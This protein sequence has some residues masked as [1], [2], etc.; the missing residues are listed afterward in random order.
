MTGYAAAAFGRA[1]VDVDHNGC[2]QRNDTLRHDL[3]GVTLKAGTN[4]CAVM[5][6]TL[7]DPYTGTVMTLP[8]TASSTS[9]VAIDHVVTLADAW[10]S[11]ANAWNQAQRTSFA[12][13]PLNLL[14]ASTTATQSKGASNASSWLPPATS[15]RCAYVARQV[16]VKVKYHLAVTAAER[17]AM[18]NVLTRCSATPLPAVTVAKLGGF[19]LYTAPA[20]KPTQKPSPKPAPSPKLVPP[21]NNCM[22]GYSPC[23]PVVA[24]L[25]CA[26][27]NGPVIVT[28]SDPYRLDRDK[29]GIGC[30]S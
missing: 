26:D 19:P 16:A 8:R 4:G 14:A 1:W 24:D 25:D 10:A 23:L 22:A 6:G 28:G 18:A 27:I 5:T 15:Y 17:E 13:D 29:D 30:E 11:G 21:S 7:T 3:R 9:P 20:P 12:N 2:D